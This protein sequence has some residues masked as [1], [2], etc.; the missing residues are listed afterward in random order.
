MPKDTLTSPQNE[1][2]PP[3]IDFGTPI[4]E[5][6]SAT[7]AETAAAAKMS[8]VYHQTAGKFKRRWGILRGDEELH[9]EGNNQEILG[10]VHR[11]VGSL[12]GL[13]EGSLKKLMNKRKETRAACIKHG[14]RM[15]DVAGD[16]AED[17]KKIILK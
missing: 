3:D 13:R 17:I 14:G 2:T 15:L 7:F 1:S 6:E 11:L 4:T 16:L 12:R 10:K 5:T 9:A 8:G